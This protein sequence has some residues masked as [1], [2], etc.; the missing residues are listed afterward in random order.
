L[1]SLKS[2]SG[3]IKSAAFSQL[4]TKRAKLKSKPENYQGENI[5]STP[6]AEAQAFYEKFN[7]HPVLKARMESLL[8]V[9]ENTNGDL[10]KAA[11]V[12]QRVIEELRQMGNEVLTDWAIQP[13][14]KTQAPEVKK[15]EAKFVVSEKKTPLAH[16]FW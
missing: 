13:V 6:L 1:S 3:V 11:E 5:M 7:R 8:E 14:E 10:V 12:E 2:L 4:L 15:G 16:H 9:V